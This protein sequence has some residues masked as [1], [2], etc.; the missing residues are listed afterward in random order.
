[1]DRGVSQLDMPDSFR[2]KTVHPA[3]SSK[4]SLN[5]K[6]AY[7]WIFGAAATVVMVAFP[8]MPAKAQAPELMLSVVGAIATFVHFLYSQ[9]NANTDR[10]MRLFREFNQR[11]DKLNNQL[12]SIVHRSGEPIVDPADHQTLY[13]YFNLCAEEFLYAEAGYIDAEVW[14]S[15]LKGMRYYASFSEVRRIWSRE[16]AQGS[17][18]G[19]SLDLIDGVH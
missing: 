10:F 7:P 9:H 16:L 6:R 8:F 3:V 18:Y 14:L 4:F 5:R 13:D 11:Y 2:S 17:Y 19:F 12:N 1:M 15:W